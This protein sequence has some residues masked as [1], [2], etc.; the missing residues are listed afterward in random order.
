M[1]DFHLGTFVALTHGHISTWRSGSKAINL[2][3]QR[4]KRPSGFGNEKERAQ[5]LRE[6]QRSAKLS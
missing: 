5:E 6:Q 4:F 2:C 3:C 1:L